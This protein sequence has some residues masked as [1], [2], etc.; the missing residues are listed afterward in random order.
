MFTPTKPKRRFKHPPDTPNEE[1]LAFGS[2][3]KDPVTGCVPWMR[4]T[5]SNGYGK[6]NSCDDRGVLRAHSMALELKLG[7]RLDK[8]E[9]ARHTCDFT[10]CVNKDHL[11]VGS[12]KDNSRDMVAR[13]RSRGQKHTDAPKQVA[14]RKRAFA[15][16]AE[17]RTQTSVAK[18]LGVSRP[19][20]SRWVAVDA[21]GASSS[22]SEDDIRD[23]RQLYS[24]GHGVAALAK[25]YG[26]SVSSIRAIVK[27]RTYAGVK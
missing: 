4:G 2:G 25:C 20:I 21:P 13:G 14:L 5:D 6:I 10:G 18:E 24:E 15:L 19:T 9:V 1:R 7:R 26:R 8:K 27:R 17:G 3:P 12:Q 22:L 16:L 11:K 23:V